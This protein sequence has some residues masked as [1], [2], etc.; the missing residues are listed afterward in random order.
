MRNVK[1]EQHL[2]GDEHWPFL[3]FVTVPG[4]TAAS[5]IPAG[6]SQPE[7]EAIIQSWESIAVLRVKP[8]VEV[9]FGFKIVDHAQFLNVPI[10]TQ[11]GKFG[12][13]V[14]DSDI[15]FF[16]FAKDMR[17]RPSLELVE[18]TSI[19]NPDYADLPLY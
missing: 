14:G 6:S 7:A 18:I 5:P 4:N 9:Y 11:D 17:T 2:D 19:N 16:V 8:S 13:H 10:V 3:A 12:V 1:L 15:D